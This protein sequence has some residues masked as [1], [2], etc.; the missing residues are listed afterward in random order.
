MAFISAS[1]LMNRRVEGRSHKC[2]LYLL[3][4]CK[5]PLSQPH[6]FQQISV[7]SFATR[8]GAADT[9][10]R[11]IRDH[12]QNPVKKELPVRRK[13]SR[14]VYITA[15]FS[16]LVLVKSRGLCV[17][18]VW[19]GSPSVI[20]KI[21]TRANT[22]TSSILDVKC[23][24]QCEKGKEVEAEKPGIMAKACT[25]QV[26][27]GTLRNTCGDDSVQQFTGLHWRSDSPLS[28]WIHQGCTDH[29]GL[30]AIKS[31][32]CDGNLALPYTFN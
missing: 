23:C 8:A 5:N 13:R 15:S 27:Q 29:H 19:A 4:Q 12:L 14:T 22:G 26:S 3:H 2:H 20:T 11:T 28:I 7:C 18:A 16:P 10:K 32:R 1:R 21:H 25:C 30:Q 17:Y 6:G 24:L 9:E 31:L